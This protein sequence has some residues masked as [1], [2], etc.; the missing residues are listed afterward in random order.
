MKVM[1]AFFK[2]LVMERPGQISSGISVQTLVGY[3]IRF[4]A[5]YER[6]HETDLGS[7]KELQRVSPTE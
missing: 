6:K 4:K 5:I 1:K 2:M 3:T 7:I